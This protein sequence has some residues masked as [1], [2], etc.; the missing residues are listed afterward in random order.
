MPEFKEL[1][2]SDGEIYFSIY[3]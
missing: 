3:V 1:W 2:A